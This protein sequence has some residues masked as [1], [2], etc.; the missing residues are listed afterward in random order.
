M[1]DMSDAIA[2][3]MMVMKLG[4]F[5]RNIAQ[6]KHALNTAHK[7]LV[8]TRSSYASV[9]AGYTAF[10]QALAKVDPEHPLVIDKALLLRLGKAGEKALE[11]SGQLSSA[12]SA[13]LKFAVPQ[14]PSGEPLSVVQYRQRLAELYRQLDQAKN[15]NRVLQAKHN[16]LESTHKQT[17]S[18]LVDS[19]SV[20]AAL[21]GEL[22]RQAP[23]SALITNSELLERISAAGQHAYNETGDLEAVY[24]EGAS[25]LMP[26]AKGIGGRREPRS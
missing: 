18:Q 25:F 26:T 3:A 6:L 1:S 22:E 8:E 10:R 12:K 24:I 5:K 16:A 20:R 2:G 7:E 17:V 4:Q 15:E 19:I 21:H 13:G 9:A 14:R 11:Q 23:E